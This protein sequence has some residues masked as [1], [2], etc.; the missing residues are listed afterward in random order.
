MEFDEWLSSLTPIRRA[1]KLGLGRYESI[2][3]PVAIAGYMRETWTR[4]TRFTVLLEHASLRRLARTRSGY[5]ALVPGHTEVGDAVGLFKGSRWPLLFRALDEDQWRL[6]GQGHV[7][8]IML[9][10]AFDERMCGRMHFR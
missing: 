6:V 9:G 3:S 2:F 5:L 8:G 4:F 10:D 1:V 7:H